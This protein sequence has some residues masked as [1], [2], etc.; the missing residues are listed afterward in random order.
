MIGMHGQPVA[1]LA[2]SACDV[3]I[4]LGTRFSDRVTGNPQHFLTDTCIIHVDID[5]P[6]YLKMYTL[7]FP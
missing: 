6:N 4:A 7:T 3:L 1:N 2:L 5:P